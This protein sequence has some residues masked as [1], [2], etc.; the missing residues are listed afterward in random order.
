[1]NLFKMTETNEKTKHING[2]FIIKGVIH[3]TDE[4]HNFEVL[5]EEF[6]YTGLETDGYFLSQDMIQ[7]YLADELMNYDWHIPIE[8]DKCY[9]VLFKFNLSNTNDYYD[10]SEII[11]NALHLIPVSDSAN[12]SYLNDENSY[13]QL[14][15]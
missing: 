13:F 3:I 4:D 14:S 6:F 9:A 2:E 10:D 5:V 8:I 11:C 1:M 7:V 12:Y 15:N